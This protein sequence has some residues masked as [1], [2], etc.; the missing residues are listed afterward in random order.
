MKLIATG[1]NV[2]D[3]SREPEG[4]VKFLGTPIEVLD[5][6]TSGQASRFIILA[7]GGTTTFLSPIHAEGTLGIL[8]MSGA[9]QSHLGILSREFQIPCVMTL[10]LEGWDRRYVPGESGA[11]Y[12]RHVVKTLDGRRVRMICSDPTTASVWSLDG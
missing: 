2:F 12:F 3:T 10:A 11:D 1:H 8:T 7:Q 6:V 9:P 4:V 5:L